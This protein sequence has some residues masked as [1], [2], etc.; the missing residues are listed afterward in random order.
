MPI[1]TTTRQIFSPPG[2]VGMTEDVAPSGTPQT[3]PWF[4]QI[5]KFEQSLRHKSNETRGFIA[6]NQG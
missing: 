5:R 6:R 2:N 1:Q 4:A 3:G